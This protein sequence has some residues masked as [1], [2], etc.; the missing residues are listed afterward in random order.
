MTSNLIVH[1]SD[2][3]PFERIKFDPD[4][5]EEVPTETLQWLE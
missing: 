3:W 5:P 4:I 2:N 1:D